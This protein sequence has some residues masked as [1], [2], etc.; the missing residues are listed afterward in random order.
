MN[1]LRLNPA[2]YTGTVT[3]E[4]LRPTRHRFD[5]RVFS[6]YLDI[7]RLD[8]TLS[9]RRLISHNR[10]NVLSFQDR[11]HGPRDGSG[12]RPWVDNMLEAHGLG[13]A[14]HRVMLL[15]YPRL[16]GFVF[17]PLSV[18]FCFRDDGS[19]GAVIHEVKNTFG[20]QHAYVLPVERDAG[21]VIR[22]GCAKDFHVSPFIPMEARYA[23]RFSVPDDQLAFVIDE[24]DAD[25]KLLIA[26][27]VGT[28]RPL[29]DRTLAGALVRHPLMT[30]K[31]IAAIHFEALRLWLKGARFHP[32]PDRH[33][34]SG[35]PDQTRRART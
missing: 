14:S 12:L 23:F 18:Y 21:P 6:L 8:E 31:V 34:R 4:R 3:H 33:A 10:A 2:I 30:L 26:A 16:W 9:P 22:Q 17:N 27:Q 7:D 15:C 5:Y 19:L 29:N 24:F 13:E 28:R 32:H 20:E 35:D 11:D 1:A 25:G